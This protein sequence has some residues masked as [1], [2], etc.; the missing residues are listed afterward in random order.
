MRRLP[1]GSCSFGKTTQTSTDYR[2]RN[3][4]G[5]EVCNDKM[6]TLKSG[7][8]K[9]K[10]DLKMAMNKNPNNKEVS[11]DDAD[12]KTYKLCLLDKICQLAKELKVYELKVYEAKNDALEA[13]RSVKNIYYKVDNNNIKHINNNHID[14]NNIDINNNLDLNCEHNINNNNLIINNNIDDD[15]RNI[16]NKIDYN[17]IN[18]NSINGNNNQQILLDELNF[19]PYK[20]VESDDGDVIIIQDYDN[21]NDL[22]FEKGNRTN[23]NYDEQTAAKDY[24]PDGRIGCRHERRIGLMWRWIDDWL[25]ECCSATIAN[26]LME[27]WHILNHKAKMEGAN[28]RKPAS[29]ESMIEYISQLENDL[30]NR[31]DVTPLN[32]TPDIRGGGAARKA[33]DSAIQKIICSAIATQ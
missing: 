12:R 23:E 24:Q 31:S 19:M 5:D 4:R 27:L 15:C 18:D 13:E 14:I 28:V 21:L 11:E 33:V 17:N 3:Q 29:D 32:F 22:K 25:N 9:L 30:I 16:P 1:T 2:E 8:E 7:N 6:Q 10:E 26:S 20:Y